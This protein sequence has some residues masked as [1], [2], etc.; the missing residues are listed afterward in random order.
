MIRRG[1]PYGRTV[2]PLE[3]HNGRGQEH[4]WLDATMKANSIQNSMGLKVRAI[5]D[6]NRTR[7]GLITYNPCYTQVTKQ[8]TVQLHYLEISMQGKPVQ[9]PVK[10][11][12]H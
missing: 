11:G 5:H 1:I 7:P 8:A 9:Q 10:T 3:Y 6:D 2:V 4:I 12:I